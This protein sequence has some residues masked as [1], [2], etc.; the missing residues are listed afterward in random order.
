ME[1]CTPAYPRSARYA[2]VTGAGLD[3]PTSAVLRE[4]DEGLTRATVANTVASHWTT[5]VRRGQPWNIGPE[6]RH[7]WTIMD[8]LPR[9][10]DL[11]LRG[12]PP[13]HD[14]FLVSFSPTRTAKSFAGRARKS[15]RLPT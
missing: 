7:A 5:P 2:P 10:T 11:G 6:R 9:T 12:M 14:Y 1:T 15:E 13:R 3:V 8:A 4:T